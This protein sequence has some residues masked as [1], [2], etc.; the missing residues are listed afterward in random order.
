MRNTRPFGSGPGE[1]GQRT[2]TRTGRTETGRTAVGLFVQF[3]RTTFFP[4]PVLRTFT[5]GRTVSFF[6]ELNE[7]ARPTAARP[8]PRD[9]S[10][11]AP[12]ERGADRATG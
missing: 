2:V 3:G 10:G 7:Q 8:V 1:K 9:T 11:R 5:T 4:V 12:G 6:P